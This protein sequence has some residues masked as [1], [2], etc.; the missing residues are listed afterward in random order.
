MV[1]DL[2]APRC[3]HAGVRLE[4]GGPTGITVV[5]RAESLRAA[6]VNLAQ[7]HRLSGRIESA[8]PLYEA[9]LV[10]AREL[11]DLET[12]AIGLLNLAMVAIGRGTVLLVTHDLDT[13]LTVVDRIIVLA[14]GKVLAKV[15]GAREWD[16][17]E[18]KALIAKT[19][20]VKLD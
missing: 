13:L 9:A 5:G 18:N 20:G 12:I 15:Y 19:L 11:G 16:T 8:E 10:L 7:L 6:L 2:T 17:T 4:C 3:D 14:R 1:R